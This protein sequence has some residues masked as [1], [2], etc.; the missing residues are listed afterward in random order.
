MAIEGDCSGSVE[1]TQYFPD[2]IRD[3]ARRKESVTK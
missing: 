3:F 1:I 2:S